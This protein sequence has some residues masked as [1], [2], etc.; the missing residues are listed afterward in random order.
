MGGIARGI[1]ALLKG[2]AIGTIVTVIMFIVMVAFFN[3]CY[4][5]VQA[6]ETHDVRINT[7]DR[8]LSGM[9]WPPDPMYIGEDYNHP[10]TITIEQATE[11]PTSSCEEHNNLWR[12]C[13]TS[14]I[15]P[16]DGRE[17]CASYIKEC[18]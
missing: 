6:H 15:I 10:H 12:V 1:C 16:K 9:H 2:L 3:G 11:A 7:S 13:L 14:P 5:V 4:S 17:R 8:S 18:K